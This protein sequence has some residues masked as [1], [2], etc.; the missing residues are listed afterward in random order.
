[1]QIRFTEREK[2][3]FV[4][5]RGVEKKLGKVVQKYEDSWNAQMAVKHGNHYNWRTNGRFGTKTAAAIRAWIVQNAAWRG[6][7]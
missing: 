1:M 6:A 3:L 4:N 5:V 7:G 2:Q